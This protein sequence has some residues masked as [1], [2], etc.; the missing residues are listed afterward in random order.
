MADALSR[1][2]DHCADLD[3]GAGHHDPNPSAHQARVQTGGDVHVPGDVGGGD[4][5]ADLHR[6][7]GLVAPGHPSRRYVGGVRNCDAHLAA[8]Y[9]RA[10]RNQR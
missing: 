3:S 2:P 10:K 8:G 6:V 1:L 9:H 5:G 7:P 4:R